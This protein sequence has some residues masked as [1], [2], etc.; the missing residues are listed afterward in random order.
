MVTRAHSL[1]VAWLNQIE[2]W[3]GLL[4]ERQIKR[5]ARRSMRALEKAIYE[6]LDAHNE[7]PAPFK[8]TKTADQILAKVAAFC[9]QTIAAQ[10]KRKE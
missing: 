10:G 1:F 9:D 6:F 3:F 7:D 5:S 2:R 4:T 8:W